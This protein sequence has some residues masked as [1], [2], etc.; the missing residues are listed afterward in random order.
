MKCK[1]AEACLHDRFFMQVRVLSDQQQFILSLFQAIVF[2]RKKILT[3]EIMS[4][5]LNLATLL[6]I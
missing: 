5:F 1:S 3:A 4:N 6:A 2:H